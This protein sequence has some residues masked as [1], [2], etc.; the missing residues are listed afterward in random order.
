M[1][2]P[3]VALSDVLR[4]LVTKDD[5]VVVKMDVEGT[6]WTLM[7]HLASTGSF[8]FI[9]EMFIECHHAEYVPK[10]PTD[11]SLAD[12]HRMFNSLRKIGVYAHEW[13]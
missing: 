4:F 11:H 6:E 13:Y 12:C 3:A 2:V 1:T 9:D 10:W 8:D 7:K 5:F